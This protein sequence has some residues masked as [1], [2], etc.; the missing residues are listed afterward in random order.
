MCT[1]KPLLLFSTGHLL[2]ANGLLNGHRQHLLLD[3]R[4]THYRLKKRL[5][6]KSL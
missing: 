6:F 5:V 2:G 4:Q 3:Q 1:K